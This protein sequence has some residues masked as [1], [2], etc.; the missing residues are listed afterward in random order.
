MK[1]NFLNIF[2]IVGLTV[3][4]AVSVSVA[5]A[6]V[7]PTA[8]ATLGNAIA[9]I[10][11]GLFSQAKLG[12]L[13]SEQF[14]VAGSVMPPG[15]PS[16]GIGMALASTMVVS[17]RGLFTDQL[18]VPGVAS[19]IKIGG[20]P[21]GFN[22]PLF[23]KGT[24]TTPLTIDLNGRS[25]GSGAREGIEL[26]SNDNMC[27]NNVTVL[28]NTA[29]HRF[30]STINPGG[31]ADVIA[32]QV[33]LSGGNPSAGK[34][35]IATNRDGDAV[36]A[37]PQLNSNG[38]I[39]F[40]TSTS[41]VTSGQLCTTPPPPVVGCMD[42]AANNYISTATADTNPTLCTYDD[43]EPAGAICYRLKSNCVGNLNGT[44]V[45][46]PGQCGS[47]IPLDDP[48]LCKPEGNQTSQE[49]VPVQCSTQITNADMTGT[50]QIMNSTING[51]QVR[52]ADLP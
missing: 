16:P 32:R 30:V 35:L 18:L 48:S 12:G 19:G 44:G 7:T 39:T 20:S 15:L 28:T 2:K 11:T 6:W 22:T 49:I 4:L 25:S 31:N 36:W 29:A 51:G 9:S 47:M 50:T 23:D 34:I 5:S 52:C 14:L 21:D 1:T 27:K 40:N 42:P 10:N 3:V 37:R 24:Y 45:I 33:R 17:Q 13:T 38:T 26:R 41:P 43:P 8:P 46:I